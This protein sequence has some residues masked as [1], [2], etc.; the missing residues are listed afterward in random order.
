M[1]DYQQALRRLTLHDETYI[2]RLLADDS[3]NRA[4]S[5]LD[6]KTHALVGVAALV[7]TGAA[8]ASYVDAVA[9][10]RRSHASSDEIVGCV[11]AVLPAVGAARAVAAAP[12]IGLALDYDVEHALE[13]RD[14]AGEII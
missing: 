12:I 4:A 3:V 5:G 9:A 11:I 14:D 2:D 6:E 10:A 7:A 8:P 13:T 1:S